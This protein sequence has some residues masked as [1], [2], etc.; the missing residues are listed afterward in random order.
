MYSWSKL[1]GSTYTWD[2]GVK[3]RTFFDHKVGGS[4]Y[5]W[6]NLYASL[7]GRYSALEVFLRRC[8]I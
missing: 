2:A 3:V 5:T 6:I 1:G 7:Y 8:A 4:T